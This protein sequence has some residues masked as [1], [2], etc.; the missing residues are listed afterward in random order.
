DVAARKINLCK[1]ASHEL[2]RRVQFSPDGRLLAVVSQG[3][4]SDGRLSTIQVWEIRS[5]NEVGIRNGGDRLIG[6]C[7]FDGE[8]QRLLVLQHNYSQHDDAQSSTVATFDL[9]NL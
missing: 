4:Q 9:E 7:A 5:G 1:A 8:G 2:V 6:H 3:D